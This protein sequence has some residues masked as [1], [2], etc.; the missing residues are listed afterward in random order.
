MDDVE[1]RYNVS[2][3][4]GEQCIGDDELRDLLA[5]KAAHIAQLHRRDLN[6]SF[7]SIE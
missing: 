7:R 5:K 2:K 6:D 4:V 1:N 3:I